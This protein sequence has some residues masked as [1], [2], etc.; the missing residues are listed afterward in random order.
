M[1]MLY[2]GGILVGI[3]AAKVLGK[4]AFRGNPVP[5]VMELPNYRFP[6]A[7]VWGSCAGTRPRTF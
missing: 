7:G 3:L 5:F 2:L 6:S 4:T 1:I